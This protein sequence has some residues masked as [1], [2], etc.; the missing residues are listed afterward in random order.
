[1]GFFAMGGPKPIG[2]LI[3]FEWPRL[4]AEGNKV[5]AFNYPPTLKE[6][7]YFVRLN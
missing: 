2:C 7:Y 5:K 4:V 3:L 6:K 1:M